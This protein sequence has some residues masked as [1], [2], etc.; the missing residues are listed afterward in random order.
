MV[1]LSGRLEALEQRPQPGAVADSSVAA[2]VISAKVE[3]A[4]KSIRKRETANKWRVG[5]EKRHAN[6]D[7]R[8]A[9]LQSSLDLNPGQVDSLRQVHEEQHRRTLETIRLWEEDLES[10]AN[11]GGLK[12]TNYQTYQEALAGILTPAQLQ[13]H[14]QQQQASGG[15]D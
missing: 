1:E 5:T 4:L 12:R 2:P 9:R 3:S 8:L 15:K 11:L 6:L 13:L 14:Q 7:R 10:E